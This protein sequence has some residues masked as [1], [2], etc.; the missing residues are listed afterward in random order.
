M[1]PT[2]LLQHQLVWQGL[3]MGANTDTCQ[4]I[5][6]PARLRK[7]Q[8]IMPRIWRWKCL[9]LY[10]G[11]Q[12]IQALH[13]MKKRSSGGYRTRSTEHRTLLSQQRA[14]KMA[15][16]LQSSVEP[17]LFYNFKANLC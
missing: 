15:Y 14:I 17:Y 11:C 2:G 16:G 8:V 4:S 3:R 10:L 13:G 1:S 6:L 9:Q 7:R 5:T 12:T